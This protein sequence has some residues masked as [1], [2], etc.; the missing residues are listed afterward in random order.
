MNLSTKIK[1]E[2]FRLTHVIRFK[3]LSEL[4]YINTHNYPNKFIMIIIRSTFCNTLIRLRL[5]L[6]Y[7]DP[8]DIL[9][10]TPALAF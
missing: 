1:G 5:R 4:G 3:S 2:V 9:L 6:T 8:I 7:K 10:L